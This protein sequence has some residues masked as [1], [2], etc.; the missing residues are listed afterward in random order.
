MV[1]EDELV[2][3]KSVAL[4]LLWIWKHLQGQVEQEQQ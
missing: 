3:G 1:D 2:Q 4:A